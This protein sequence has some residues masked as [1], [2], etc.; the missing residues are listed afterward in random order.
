MLKV[1]HGRQPWRA[2]FEDHSPSVQGLDTKSGGGAQFEARAVIQVRDK[3]PQERT[4]RVEGHGIGA[5]NKRT[6]Q[7]VLYHL[8]M[9]WISALCSFKA[10]SLS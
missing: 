10:G 9:I 5:K 6:L 4:S 7:I 3:W 8:E 1:S 2:C